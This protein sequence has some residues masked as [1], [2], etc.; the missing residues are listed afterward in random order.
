MSESLTITF[1]P[2]EGAIIRIV[3]LIE[4][5]GFDVHNLNVSE[6][7]EMS[8]ALRPRDAGRRIDVLAQHVGKLVDVRT[9]SI[10]RHP[11]GAAA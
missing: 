6:S 1:A 3:G 2:G 11:A 5:R 4:R 7:G 10:E 9:V 8:V